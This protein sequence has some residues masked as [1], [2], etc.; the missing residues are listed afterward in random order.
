MLSRILGYVRDAMIAAYFG[1]G[2]SSD[3]FFAAFRI[4]NF[5]KRLV[6]E[7]ALNS[8]FV[9]VFSE[10]LYRGGPK[11]AHRL[12][13][14]ACGLFTAVLVP[15]CALGIAAAAWLVP[16]ITPGFSGD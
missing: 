10:T 13:G 16:L 8:A 12:F 6:G 15:V 3:A 11:E 2:F 9:P 14:S 5:F 4:P 7:G 1:A